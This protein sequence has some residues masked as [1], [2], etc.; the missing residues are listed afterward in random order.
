M[1]TKEEQIAIVTGNIKDMA[2]TRILQKI[3]NDV[4]EA[5]VRRAVRNGGG[6]K[7]PSDL[8][9]FVD[10]QLT[11]RRGLL[12]AIF[13]DQEDEPDDDDETSDDSEGGDARLTLVEP[14]VPEDQE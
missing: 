5:A 7:S 4:S 12:D 1:A 8:A 14:S 13:Y 3:A 6:F 9:E 11:S 10:E 2:R